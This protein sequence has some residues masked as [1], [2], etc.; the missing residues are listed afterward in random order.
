MNTMNDGRIFDLAIS[1]I[2]RQATDAQRAELDALLTSRPEL[3]AEYERLQAEVMIAKETLPL[4]NATEAT[5]GELPAY[6]RGRLQSKVRQ[7]LGR[8]TKD[9]EPDRSLAWGWKWLLGLAPAAAI[10]VVLL[11]PIVRTPNVLV[12]Q[13]AML[14]M[15]GGTRG[16]ETDASPVLHQTWA[17]ATLAVF[18]SPELLRTWETNWSS[19]QNSVKIIYDPAAAEVRVLGKYH[20]KSFQETFPIVKDFPSTLN[21]VKAFVTEQTRP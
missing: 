1:V 21:R 13:L 7:T 17:N 2:A 5:A 18:T 19:K 6:A 10:V 11:L 14:D 4:V 20:G 8:P 15:T 9:K 12:I 3:K 16:T